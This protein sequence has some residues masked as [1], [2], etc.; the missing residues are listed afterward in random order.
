MASTDELGTA[1]EYYLVQRFRD[2]GRSVRRH[3]T[4][5]DQLA[6]GD[7]RVDGIDVEIK[8]DQQFSMTGNLFIE[9]A[10]RRRVEGGYVPSG[11]FAT[12]SARWYCVGD[13]SH[14]WLFRRQTLRDVVAPIREI[15]KRTSRGWLLRPTQRDELCVS[16]RHW[17]DRLPLGEPVRIMP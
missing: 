5:H 8:L 9:V 15:A 6:Y 10:E 7:L 2:E 13:Y 11:I 17:P 16:R 12:S 4:R 3:E 1:F 14:C